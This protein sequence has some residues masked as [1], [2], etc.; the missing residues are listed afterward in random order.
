MASNRSLEVRR[1]NALTREISYGRMSKRIIV[2][3]VPREYISMVYR[4]KEI[5]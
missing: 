5:N 4:G 1:L 2:V 3:G